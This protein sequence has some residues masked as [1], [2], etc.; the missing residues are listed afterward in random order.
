MYA[1]M[2]RTAWSGEG[3]WGGVGRVF[4]VYF[5]VILGLDMFRDINEPD[6]DGKELG[7]VKG[8]RIWISSVSTSPS[9]PCCGRA[10]VHACMCACVHACVDGVGRWL[11]R[12]AV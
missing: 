7:F 1:L 9:T 11:V 6:A 12:G 2:A 4:L 5:V 3:D 8:F 10:C